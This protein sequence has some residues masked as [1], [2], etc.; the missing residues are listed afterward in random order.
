MYWC[1]FVK[2]VRKGEEENVDRGVLL[3]TSKILEGINWRCV[4]ASDRD[5]ASGGGG[6]ELINITTVVGV[7]SLVQHGLWFYRSGCV[8]S[9]LIVAVTILA[10][11]YLGYMASFLCSHFLSVMRVTLSCSMWLEPRCLA[12]SGS[13]AFPNMA[14]FYISRFS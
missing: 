7:L 1:I 11:G 13:P 2:G 14:S 3:M 4:I 10:P 12:K 6:V 8:L 9:F 5:T